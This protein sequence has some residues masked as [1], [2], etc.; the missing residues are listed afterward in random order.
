M[1]HRA[2]VVCWRDGDILLVTRTGSRWAL[3]G[4]TVKRGE[5]PVEA[6]RREL[7]EETGLISGEPSY[8][9][10]FRGLTKAHHVFA[11][12]V[13]S[14]ENAQ[15]RNEIE[16]CRWFPPAKTTALSASVPTREIVQLVARMTRE[17]V[18]DMPLD[19]APSSG[20]SGSMAPELVERQ[21]VDPDL[22]L[23]FNA[24]NAHLPC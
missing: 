12:Q 16:E 11:V 24:L 3:P 14:E 19:A 7:A 20:F 22:G 18:A 4:G 15:P 10:Q 13:A 6:A 21:V 17:E 23:S 8:L 1:K 9:F 5:T 2:T